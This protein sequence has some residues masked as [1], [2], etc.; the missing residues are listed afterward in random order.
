MFM[1]NNENI[2]GK[3]LLWNTDINISVIEDI[4]RKLK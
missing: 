3:Y 1:L 4:L 2:I